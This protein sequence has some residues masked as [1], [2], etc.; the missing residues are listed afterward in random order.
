MM[1]NWFWN[2]LYLSIYCQAFWVIVHA[3][4]FHFYL[5]FRV[6]EVGWCSEVPLSTLISATGLFLSISVFHASARVVFV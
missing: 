1:A 5:H 3:V 2:S 6:C 4:F